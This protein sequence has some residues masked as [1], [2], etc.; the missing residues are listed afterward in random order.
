MNSIKLEYWIETVKSSFDENGICATFDIIEKVATD[1]L[2]SSEC[3]SMAFPT[4]D[5]PKESSQVTALKKKHAEDIK[6]YE[7][8][9]SIF[10]KSVANR[11]GVDA[12]DVYI[13]GDSVMYKKY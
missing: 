2:N 5:S 1:M 12:S 13:E 10:I 4:P 3:Q 6:E 9:E 11:R 7:R 8:R